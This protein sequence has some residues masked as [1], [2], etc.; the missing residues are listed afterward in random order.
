MR[1]HLD[2]VFFKQKRRHFKLSARLGKKNSI[3][4]R[5][6]G[7]VSLMADRMTKSC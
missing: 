7:T 4:F 3:V 6:F 5:A 2:R 1:N